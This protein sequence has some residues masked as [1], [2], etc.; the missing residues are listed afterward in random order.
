[1]VKAIKE[2]V[3]RLDAIHEKCDGEPCIFIAKDFEVM[4]R[5]FL[6]DLTRFDIV[7]EN[8]VD[9]YITTKEDNGT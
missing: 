4:E 2:L 9:K 3:I 6:S 1:M 7:S 5:D 8:Y